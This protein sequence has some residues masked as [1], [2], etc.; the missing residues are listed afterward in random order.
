MSESMDS[1]G[2]VVWIGL[3]AD[4]EVLRSLTR[5]VCRRDGLQLPADSEDD[6]RVEQCPF[7]NRIGPPGSI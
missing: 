4:Y 1:L 2:R 3:A 5:R 7:L 6:G